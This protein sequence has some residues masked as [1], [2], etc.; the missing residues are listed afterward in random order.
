MHVPK[1]QMYLRRNNDIMFA[2]FRYE[3]GYKV[4]D[5][6]QIWFDKTSLE[7][8]ELR[9]PSGTIQTLARVVDSAG[10]ATT[11]FTDALIVGT[12]QRRLQAG[13]D[14][15]AAIDLVTAKVQTQHASGVN[16]LSTTIAVEVARTVPESA[17][18]VIQTLMEKLMEA[19]QFAVVN[20][21]YFCQGHMCVCVCVC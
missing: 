13:V 5:G 20:K 18:L 9:L 1:L 3:F 16:Q 12:S 4:G 14:F 17:P 2:F 11:V 8:I 10:G 6:P 19:L 21:E 15:I 7:S